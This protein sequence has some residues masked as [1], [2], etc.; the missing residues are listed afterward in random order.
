MPAV[1]VLASAWLVS[2]GENPAG[3]EAGKQESEDV[4]VAVARVQRHNLEREL[5][6]AAEFRPYQEVEVHAK[7][8]G[9]LR[10]LLVDVGDTV[11]AGQLIAVLEVPEVVQELSQ[12]RA[13]E[14]R[15]E[16]EIVRA[17][18]E[19]QRAEA[20]H[21][22]RVIS[23]E[24]LLAVSKVRPNLIAQ[25][26][27]DNAAAQRREAEAQLATARAALDVAESQVAAAV[28]ARERVETMAGYLRI[29]APFSGVITKR[30]ADPG[31]MIQAGTASQTQARPVVRLSQ[32]SH[33]RLVLPVPESMVPAVRIGAAVRV[34]VPSLGRTYQGKVSRYTGQVQSSTRTM[35]TEVDVPN[36]GLHLMP[37]M[38]GYA[39]LNVASRTGALAV[40]IQAI[41][42]HDTGEPKVMVVNGD[43]QLEERIV[44][45]GIETPDQVEVL[46]GLS[47]GDLVVMAGRNQLRAGQSVT[48]KP[49]VTAQVEVER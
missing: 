8:A 44:R 40:P 11:G 25:Q 19:I 27:L 14:K 34:R 12:A 2:C 42:G 41:S 24:R 31:A 10:E 38:Y 45:L 4:S 5:E 9:F 47:E 22:I 6:L 23:Y 36:P 35:E 30:Y 16:L 1:L 7:V 37:G 33:L 43:N 26:E 15:S 39:N 48:P 20:A 32:V 28:A 3:L 13:V 18:G 29:T 49:F 21:E 46:A 17:Q